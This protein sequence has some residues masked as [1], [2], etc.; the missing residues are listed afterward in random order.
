MY[1]CIPNTPAADALNT[2]L[3]GIQSICG[4]LV[5]PIIGVDVMAIPTEYIADTKIFLVGS[6]ANHDEVGMRVGYTNFSEFKTNCFYSLCWH[7][8]DASAV[9]M[10]WSSFACLGG[11]EFKTFPRR[12]SRCLTVHSA[13]FRAYR[14]RKGTVSDLGALGGCGE[15]TMVAILAPPSLTRTIQYAD[16]GRIDVSATIAVWLHGTQE[17]YPL[18]KLTTL[19]CYTAELELDVLS[20][21]VQI[22][23]LVAIAP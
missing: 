11:I 17:S 14:P 6:P 10:T 22:G 19:A 5:Q 13:F 8:D 15:D 18:N 16:D 7:S 21:A 4:K 23:R 1:P 20:V 9:I 3:I 12:L 2:N